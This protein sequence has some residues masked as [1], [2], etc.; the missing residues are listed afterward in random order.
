VSKFS[1]VSLFSGL[2]NLKDITVDARY[3]AICGYT[4]ADLDTVFAPELPGLDRAQIRAWYNGYNWTGEA[5]YNPFDVLLLFDAR[6]FRPWWF[7]TA[8]PKF[9]V[10]LLIER[11]VFVPD[12]GR[13]LTSDALLSS[14]DVDHI[15]T[16][17]LLFQAGYLTIDA[18]R[19]L[20]ALIEYR[21]RWPNL[22]VQASLTG[23]LLDQI[24]PSTHRPGSRVSRLYELLLAND[25]AG[26][27]RFFTALYD[28]IPPDWYRNNKIS[29]YEGH[30]AGVFYAVFAA[31]GLDVTP[32]EASNAGRLDLAL[33]FNGQI[34]RKPVR[35]GRRRR[36]NLAALS[37]RAFTPWRGAPT[38]G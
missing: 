15:A 19:Q 36:P 29:R 10:D 6:Q 9:L 32:E 34:W 27:E 5:V 13:M 1:K 20:G 26:L 3:S 12:L 22:E 33:R 17:A 16:E 7:E 31:L 37:G 23:A 11:E 8:T 4:E 24:A 18:V 21:L 35:H 28:A 25:F 38:H 30:S 2:N 14:F